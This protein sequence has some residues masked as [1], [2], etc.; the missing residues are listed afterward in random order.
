[1][2]LANGEQDAGTE[3]VH[4]ATT[5]VVAMVLRREFGVRVAV[6]ELCPSVT[7]GAGV[8]FDEINLGFHGWSQTGQQRRD[9]ARH[10]RRDFDFQLQ[11]LAERLGRQAEFALAL[12]G[13]RAWFARPFVALDPF[14]ER[15]GDLGQGRDAF[16]VEIVVLRLVG[17]ARSGLQ[18]VFRQQPAP[19]TSLAV[20][21]VYI[22]TSSRNTPVV[23][24]C[25]TT[26][27]GTN[28]RASLRRF[29]SSGTLLPNTPRS[30]RPEEKKY[31][32][33]CDRCLYGW[34]ETQACRY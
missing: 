17:G 7:A 6:V 5:E 12:D 1:L 19:D 8:G 15:R 24:E 10:F 32:T 31:R 13:K 28:T 30:S 20:Q 34:N 18:L 3:P 26:A 16:G 27:P 21:G 33:V 2:A 25:S 14:A 11:R 22:G 23:A 9:L 4:D 29:G